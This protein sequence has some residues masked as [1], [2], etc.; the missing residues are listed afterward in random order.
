M[1]LHLAA[2]DLA[3]VVEPARG[4]G[5]IRFDWRGTPLMVGRPADPT[6]LGLACFP[7]LPFSNRIAFGHFVADGRAIELPAN[8][9]GDPAHPHALHGYA[10]QLPWQVAKAGPAQCRLTLDVPAGVWP[11]AWRGEQRLTLDHDGLTLHIALENRGTTRMPAGIG[12]H[13]YFPCNSQTLFDARFA[14]EWQTAPDGL[15]VTLDRRGSPR[16]WWDGAPIATRVLDTVYV[17]RAGDMV[18]RWPDRGLALTIAASPELPFTVVY[19][20]PAAEYVCI[21]AVSQMTDAV[22]RP[23]PAGFTGRRWLEPGESHAG[24]TRYTVVQA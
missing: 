5:I 20:P 2:G 14:G 19:V 23:E 17:G 22:N 8:H 11:W 12:T 15:P 24:T 10:W 1:T 4:G 13:P 18:L 16:D 9:P 3:L 6:P 21:E 7:L